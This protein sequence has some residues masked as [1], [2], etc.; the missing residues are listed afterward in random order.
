MNMADVRNLVGLWLAERVEIESG[1][2]VSN[3]EAFNDFLEWLKV[4]SD[5][6]DGVAPNQFDAVMKSNNFEQERDS[7]GRFI[8]CGI[9]L[10][11]VEEANRLI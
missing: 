9:K 2:V 10:K 6:G 5:C 1:V 7:S 8:I 4:Q 3:I 11:E